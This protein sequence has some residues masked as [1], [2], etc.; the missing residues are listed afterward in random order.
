M[1][2]LRIRDLGLSARLWLL[3]S[4][5]I[6]YGTTIPFRFVDDWRV[7][8]VHLSA[9][10]PD[11][12]AFH[13]PDFVAN[14]VLF[15]PFG[16]CGSLA[17]RRRWRWSFLP[18]VGLAFLLAT[19]LEIA[20]LFT[21]DRVT[22]TSDVLAAVIGA[23]AGVL[24]ARLAGAVFL[25]A[26]R[27]ADVNRA[28][29]PRFY[30][31]FVGLLIAAGSLWEPFD[32]SLDVGLI[33][34][35]VKSLAHDPWQFTGIND[36]GV[37]ILRFALAALAVHAWLREM[38]RVRRPAVVTALVMT[39]CAFGLEASQFIIDSRMPGLE[40]ACVSAAGG[41]L[42]V[43]LA[44]WHIERLKPSTLTGMLI[45]TTGATAALVTL[46]PFEWREAH[47]G[48]ALLP[49]SNY[50]ANTSSAGVSH[51][52]EM[53]LLYFPIG[54]CVPLIEPN[55]RRAAVVSAASVLV[56][57]VGLEFCQGWVVGR[58]SDA[59]DTALALVGAYVG[60]WAAVR[61]EAYL[62]MTLK[63]RPA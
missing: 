48:M 58:Y 63:A 35:K 53:M 28:L 55:R 29:G 24:V 31:A 19:T 45:V 39:T 5:F 23:D 43:C 14:I 59:T 10:N 26:F 34:G 37:M 57:A 15:I 25:R 61:G 60:W 49:F 46:S 7:A 18:I 8:L 2:L 9:V 17:L 16:I 20:Q 1:T 27:L 56:L 41:L 30:P 62:S 38:G 4:A 36:E 42:G 21:V 50:Y 13:I 32:V 12:L 44:Q 40:D 6:V 3:W 52:I 47:S 33:W 11:P 54:F 51:A 22:A